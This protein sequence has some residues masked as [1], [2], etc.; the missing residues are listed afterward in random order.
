MSYDL[1]VLDLKGGKKKKRTKYIVAGVG[2]AAIVIG[3]ALV[4]LFR[5]V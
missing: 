1:G 4:I 2:A 5:L 3:V